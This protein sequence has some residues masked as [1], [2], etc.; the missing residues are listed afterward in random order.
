MYRSS[1]TDNIGDALALVGRLL[2]AT[3]YLWSGSGKI[4]GFAGTVGYIAKAGVPMPEVGA[5]I[6]IFV[7]IVLCLMLVVGWQARWAA[8]GMAIFTLVISPIFHGYWAVP[9]AQV[10]MQKLNFFKNMSIAGGLLA[11]A[12]FGAG[13]FSVDARR[14]DRVRGVQPA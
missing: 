12:A 14:S 9:D 5:A 1:E 6:A 4:T 13:R 2:V 3:L 10:Y 11:F 7:E 8:L